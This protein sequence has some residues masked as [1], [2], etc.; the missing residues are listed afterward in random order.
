MFRGFQV[1]AACALAS[2]LVGGAV[3]VRP[4][5]LED[6]CSGSD[7]I[8]LAG[9]QSLE[10]AWDAQQAKIETTVTLVPIE[11]WKG[12]THQQIP[13]K[14]PGGTVGAITMKC[15]EA[16][17]FHTDDAVV[18]FLR[19]RDGVTEV[20]GWFRGKYTVVDGQIRELPDTSLDAFRTRTLGIVN[21]G[22]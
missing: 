1:V 13:V 11:T 16:P 8:V 2:A 20:Y 5:T 4:L 17:T 15:G 9:V 14:V 18:C 12:A 21:T 3:S 19:T 22:R 6:L 7:T 10:S